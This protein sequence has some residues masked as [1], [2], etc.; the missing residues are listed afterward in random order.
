M[1]FNCFEQVE[2][3]ESI[4]GFKP[5]SR[6]LIDSNLSNVVEFSSKS[7]SAASIFFLTLSIAKVYI[8]PNGFASCLI[9]FG[10][11]QMNLSVLEIVTPDAKIPFVLKR[12][13]VAQW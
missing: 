9:F 6:V 11:R 7:S 4:F 10:K 3:A 8:S 5:L 2:S 12:S 13:A 1:C